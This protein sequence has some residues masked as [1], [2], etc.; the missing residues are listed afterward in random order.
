MSHP[1]TPRRNKL[2]PD[3]NVRQAILAAASKSVQE[4]GVRGLS[5]AAVLEHAQLSTRAFYRHFESK[6]QLVTAVFQEMTRDE[7]L[8]L[9]TKMAQAATPIA[10]VVA[11]IDGRLDLAFDETMRS[12]LRWVSLEAEPQMVSSPDLVSSAY[13]AILEPLIE[14][15]ERGLETGD[16][17]DIVPLTAAKSIHGV[18][19]AGTQRQCAMGH[20]DRAEV[21]DRALRFCLRGLGVT[22]TTI[23]Q[24]TAR[25]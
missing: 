15:L 24:V 16:F 9:R 17:Q 1:V 22:P 18:V 14:Q 2:A 6:D 12:E 25:A 8:R 23:E 11:W 10:A 20:R 19:W 5:V 13:T 3:P 21:R 7:V 4:Q